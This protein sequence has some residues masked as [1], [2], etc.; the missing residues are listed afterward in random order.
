MWLGPLSTPIDA[1]AAGKTVDER[2]Q[3]HRRPDRA[4]RAADRFGDGACARRFLAARLRQRD[5]PA[6][7]DEPAAE[8]DPVRVGPELVGPRRAVDEDD[9]ALALGRRTGAR[10]QA[11]RRRRV[12]ARAERRGDELA[13]AVERV[14]VLPDPD[15]V[16]REQ[17]RRPL[18]AGAVGA[19]RE[20]V[21]RPA[22]ERRDQRRL[23]QALQ[24]EDSVVAVAAQ[25]RTNARSSARVVDA[26]PALPR[27]AAQRALDHLGDAV[28]ASDERCERR[29]DDPVDPRVG[30]RGTDVCDD[31]QGVDDVAE[32]RQLDD[33]DAHRPAAAAPSAPRTRAPR[34]NAMPPALRRPA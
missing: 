5:V 33:Q 27:P 7:V 21:A 19:V 10:A 30:M 26:P 8:L 29:L 23:R 34:L 14:A 25:P 28:D 20:A 32:R 12:D 18:V 3:L 16:R 11:E 22:R 9:G 6:L 13:R 15:R 4:A 24:L 31:R 17:A 2:T 1:G